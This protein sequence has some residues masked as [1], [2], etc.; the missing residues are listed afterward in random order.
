[1]PADWF[2]D[3]IR[4]ESWRKYLAPKLTK[5]SITFPAAYLPNTYSLPP[6][7]FYILLTEYIGTQSIPITLL[8]VAYKH[9]VP[10]FFDCFY[11]S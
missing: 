7:E 8:F 4:K 10:T 5:L 11:V 2:K 3:M 1:M 9:W 6:Q